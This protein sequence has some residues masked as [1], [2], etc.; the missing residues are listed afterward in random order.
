M[1]KMRKPWIVMFA[2]LLLAAHLNLT[3]LVPLQVGDAPP[4]WWVGGRLLWPF[5]EETHTLLS[6]DTLNAFTPMLSVMST[7]CFLMAAAALLRWRVPHTWFPWLI[8]AGIALSVV[9]QV[10]WFTGWAVL[11]LVVDMALLWAVFRQNVSVDCLRA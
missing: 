2:L 10:F 4:P 5:A 9:L 11:P 1:S 7:L 6:K 8:V 3:A